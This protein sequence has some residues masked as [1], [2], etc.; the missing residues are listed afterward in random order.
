MRVVHKTQLYYCLRSR[1]NG[2]RTLMEGH[3]DI[4]LS[5]P[6]VYFN[7]FPL[8]RMSDDEVWPVRIPS[9]RVLPK[10]CLSPTFLRPQERDGAC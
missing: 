4:L 3:T 7:G 5:H 8:R 9:Q 6:A 10:S 2:E 1:R